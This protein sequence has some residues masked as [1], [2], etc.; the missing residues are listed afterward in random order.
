MSNSL[1]I[2]TVTA[3][4]RNLLMQVT[5]DPELVDTGVTTQPLDRAYSNN[6]ANQLN[7]FLYQ[8][9]PNAAW[10]NQEIPQRTKPGETGQ[11][12]LAL[13]LFYL[14]TAYGRNDDEILSN[15]VLGAAMS[16]LH[17]HPLLGTTE[18]RNALPENDLHQ[19]IERIRIIPHSLSLE[20]LSKLWTTFQTQ[21]RI[22]AAYQASVVLI[23]SKRPTRTPLPVLMRGSGDSGVKVQPSLQ[24]PF[25]TLT[26]INPPNQQPNAQLGDTLSLEGYQLD[27]DEVSINLT[28]RYLESGITITNDD[29]LTASATTITWQIP[30]NPTQWVAGLYA[31]VVEISRDGQT[32]SSNT[33][34]LA[35]APQILSEPAI[36][37]LREGEDVT[38][39]IACTPEVQPEQEV[40]LLLGD[41]TIPSQPHPTQTDTL[42]FIAQNAA[43]GNYWV[44]LRIDGV[45][46]LLIDRTTKPPSFNPSQEVVLP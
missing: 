6:G 43:S 29:L 34:T 21:Y 46:S 39:T 20:E 14:I 38:L 10:R 19:Q 30:N 37:I 5:S 23:D 2:A 4:M 24:P 11:P 22:S 18:I 17:N 13:D 16:V 35:V 28:N 3:T 31:V 12:P 7:L 36:E 42:T 8:T 32:R 40:A 26:A 9:M 15:R 25:P 33:I 45:D 44:R 1:A 41:R 27:G